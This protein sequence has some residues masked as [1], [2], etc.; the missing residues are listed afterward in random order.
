MGSRT[1]RCSGAPSSRLAGNVSQEVVPPGLAAAGLL[2]ACGAEP[3]SVVVGAVTKGGAGAQAGLAPASLERA[4]TLNNLGIVARERFDFEQAEVFFQQSMAIRR[5]LVPGSAAEGAPGPGG[6]HPERRG[7]GRRV[8]AQR[9]PGRSPGRV[10]LP[11]SGRR[12][13][14]GDGVR[15]REELLLDEPA[16]GRGA[17]RLPRPNGGSSGPGSSTSGR[18]QGT[19]V[20]RRRGASGSGNEAG[21][22]EGRPLGGP[23]SRR[24]GAAG[25]ARRGAPSSAPASWKRWA[26]S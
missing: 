5:R 9:S 7:N 19:R 10:R 4:V 1:G 15:R 11:R 23:R 2:L 16:R 8:A 22:P 17:H 3:A 20:V 14:A 24:A 13:P 6:R 21:R 25:D 18:S 12:P 26:A